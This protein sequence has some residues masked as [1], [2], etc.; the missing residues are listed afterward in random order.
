MGY[1]KRHPGWRI[2]LALARSQHGVVTREQLLD[3]GLSAQAIKHRIARG[4]LHPVY[5]G[6]YAV[7]RPELTREGRLLAAVLAC[8]RGACISHGSA[9]ELWEIGPRI[10]VLHVSI[11]P[12]RT[13][14]QPGIVA[15]RRTGLEPAR[16]RIE[17]AIP[18]TDVLQTLIDL[19]PTLPAGELQAMIGAADRHDLSNPEQLR[20]GLNEVRQGPGVGVLRAALDR[21]TLQLTDSELERRLIPIAMRAGLGRPLTQKWVNGYRVDFCWPE[22]GLVVE[23]DGLRY[24]RTAAQQTADARRD[25]AHT[26]AGLTP[27][28]FS[29][30][31]ITYAPDEV[32]ETLR[33]VQQR[34]L[35]AG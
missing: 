35:A 34:L 28:R 33:A 23:A 29:H 14:K 3:L 13:V 27:L 11:C 24:H 1:L 31:Q 22:L 12:P 10:A 19:A 20:A 26:A 7:G 17:R 6:V 21:H 15:H 18:V 5:R 16:M 32:E 8:G 9:A 4:K 30:A 2:V 25:Q